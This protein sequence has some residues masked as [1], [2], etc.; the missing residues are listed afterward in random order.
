MASNGTGQS[1]KNID[2]YFSGTGEGGC[3]H[4]KRIYKLQKVAIHPQIFVLLT[5]GMKFKTSTVIDAFIN[6]DRCILAT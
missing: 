3:K 5:R 4:K 2:N 6:R 1:C